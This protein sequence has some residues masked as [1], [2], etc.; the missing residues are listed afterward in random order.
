MKYHKALAGQ[1]SG[2][3]YAGMTFGVLIGTMATEA[4]GLVFAVFV[5]SV[6]VVAMFVS[7]VRSTNGD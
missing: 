3:F 2:F 1:D 7:I 5:A 6:M 4:F